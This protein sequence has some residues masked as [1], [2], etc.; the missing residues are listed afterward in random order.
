[1]TD[2]ARAKITIDWFVTFQM[3]IMRKQPFAEH[4]EQFIQTGPLVHRDVIDLV[5]GFGIRGRGGEQ[6]YLH[7]VLDVTEVPAGFAVAV[8]LD[9]V[10]FHHGRDPFG[11]HGCIR[12][13]RVLARAK[14]VE[15]AQADGFHVVAAGE[16]ARIKFID[17]FGH[18]VGRERLADSVL[19]FWQPGFVAVDGA[20]RRIDKA[21]GPGIARG[22]QHV[23]KTAHIARVGVERVFQGARHRTQRSLMGNEIHGP[24]RSLT[25]FEVTDVSFDELESVPLRW[26]D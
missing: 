7:H 24:A 5:D 2:V 22:D 21:F 20:A 4:G 10:V 13:V 14:D 12:P 9:R 11:D 15:I 1:M 19:D 26:F 23:Q 3:G 25:N 6:V 8:D 18:G 17:V 16:D